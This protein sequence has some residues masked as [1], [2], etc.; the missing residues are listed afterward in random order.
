M[1]KGSKGGGA[2]VGGGAAAG[3]RPGRTA[4]GITYVKDPRARAAGDVLVEVSV[5]KLDKAWEKDGAYLIPP[6]GG[7]DRQKYQNARAF[8]GS[9]KK[10]EA[11]RAHLDRKGGVSFSDGR[12]RAAAV[13]DAGKKT[14][15][16]TV[17]RGQAARVRRELGP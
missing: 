4:G 13:R 15:Y 9:G 7:A 3:S 14:M 6:G 8:V 5:A 1:G 17:S 2:G 10:V 11:P 12:H 16:V